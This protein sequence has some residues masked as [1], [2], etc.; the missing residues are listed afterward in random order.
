MAMKKHGLDPSCG[1]EVDY[2]SSLMQT[3]VMCGILDPDKD[4]EVN[5]ISEEE[6]LLHMEASCLILRFKNCTGN[7]ID[8]SE[9]GK[10]EDISS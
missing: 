1:I 3:F 2:W 4:D 5:F 7:V 9:Q 6:L 10:K 8:F